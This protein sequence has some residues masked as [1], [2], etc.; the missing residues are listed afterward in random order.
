[1]GAVIDIDEVTKWYGSVIALTR[2]TARIR[3]G[4]TALLGPNG[5]GK[6]TLIGIMTGQ[7]R[8]TR[9]EV[10]VLGQPVWVFALL[11]VGTI[12]WRAPGTAPRRP[13]QSVRGAGTGAAA[14]DGH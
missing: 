13:A 7:I 4:I 8:A 9:G 6:S 12:L 3:P 1:M 14:R 5:A 10:R 11:A 2:V